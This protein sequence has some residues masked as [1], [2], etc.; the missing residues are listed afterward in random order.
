MSRD[1]VKQT[2]LAASPEGKADQSDHSLARLIPDSEP[3]DPAIERLIDVLAKAHAKEDS[4][5]E[6]DEQEPPP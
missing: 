1:Q 4:Q 6:I 3:L 5:R 2:E